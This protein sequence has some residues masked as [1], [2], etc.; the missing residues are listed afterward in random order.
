MKGREER[1]EEEEQ[2]EQE[3]DGGREEMKDE[4]N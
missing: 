3:G 4:G 2:K 1:W